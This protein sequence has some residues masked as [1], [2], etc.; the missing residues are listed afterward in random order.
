MAPHGVPPSNAGSVLYA[1]GRCRFPDQEVRLPERCVDCN[2]GPR[3][4]E[5]LSC[6]SETFPVRAPNG[7]PYHL[8][9]RLCLACGMRFADRRQLREYLQTRLPAYATS[10]AE[11]VAP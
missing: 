3:L 4:Q 10:V 7:V 11:A 1:V 9:L 5:V 8:T 2:S 6:Y